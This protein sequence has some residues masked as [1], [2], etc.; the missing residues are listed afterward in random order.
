MVKLTD[1]VLRDGHQSLLA[2]RMSTQDMLPVAEKLDRV[3]YFSLEAWGGATFDTALRYLKEDPWQRARLLH[4]AMPS[5]PLQML[6]RGQNILGYHHYPD[7]IVEHF[8]NCAYRN[9]IQVFRIFDALNDLRNLET[10]IRACRAIGAHVQGA[11]SYTVSP[12]HTLELYRQMGQEL[13]ALEVDSICI[14][15]MAGLLTPEEGFRLIQTLKEDH[16]LPIHLHSHYTSGMASATFMRA[17]EA[18]VDVLDTALSP[19]ALGTSHPPTESVIAMFRD[20]PYDTG[21]D[22]ELV[23]S[24]SEHF[25]GVRTRLAQYESHFT[26][27]DTAVLTAQVPG[28]MMSNLSNQLREQNALD[29]MSEVM[30]EVPRVR[31]EMGYPPL[32]TPTSQIVGVQ[33]VLNVLFGRYEMISKETTNYVKGMYGRSPAPLDPTIKEKVLGQEAPLLERPADLLEPGYEQA[34]SEV[35]Q[36]MDQPDEEDILSYA[37]FPT[38]AREYFKAREAGTAGIAN[39][40]MRLLAAAIAALS[41]PRRSVTEQGPTTPAWSQASRQHMVSRGGYLE[42]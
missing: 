41:L 28:G 21:L 13:A 19:L 39:R 31:R 16:E 26:G 7:D 38:V 20:T 36:I 32:V 2:T 37:L 1:V 35:A 24:I 3:G 40:D 10:S 17:V 18:G 4:E 14:K 5:T 8:V 6:L 11:I 9:G 12:V 22:L 30:E 29:R 15:D 27:V 33:S 34:R 42:M 23:A 25:K